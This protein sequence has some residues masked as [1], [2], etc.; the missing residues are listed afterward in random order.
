MEDVLSGTCSNHEDLMNGYIDD[1]EELGLRNRDVSIF[2]PRGD[3]FLQVFVG[4]TLYEPPFELVHGPTMY[5]NGS[6]GIAGPTDNTTGSLIDFRRGKI[7]DTDWISLD[8]V[9]KWYQMC[10]TVHGIECED[11][12]HRKKLVGRPSFLIDVFN[13]CI[14]SGKPE[15]LYIA[16]SYVWGKIFSC[17]LMKDNLETLQTAHALREVETAESI[18][19]TIRH[20]ID[21]TRQLGE[22]Y[23]WV[24]M[25][26]IVQDERDDLKAQELSKMGDIYQNACLTI[27]AADGGHADHG[28]RGIREISQPLKRSCTQHVFS[29]GKNAKAI[30]RMFRKQNEREEDDPYDPIT[31]YYRRAWTFQEY[32]FSRRRVIF[33]KGS[34]LW[35]CCCTTWFEDIDCS[36]G[37]KLGQSAILGRNI[38]LFQKGSPDLYNL[39][40]MVNS[41]NQRQ[42]TYEEDSLSAFSGLAS[43][44]SLSF[45]GGFLCGLPELFFDIALL[46]QPDGELRRRRNTSSEAAFSF[47]QSSTLPSWSWAGWAGWAGSTDVWSWQSGNDFVKRGSTGSE[48][49]RETLPITSW[50]SGEFPLPTDCREISGQWYT[51]KQHFQNLN[52]KPPKGWTRHESPGTPSGNTSWVYPDCPPPEGYGSYYFTHR[53]YPQLQFWYPIPLHEEGAG[54]TVRQPA[55]YLFASVDIATFYTRGIRLKFHTPSVTIEN[56]TGGWAGIL[57]P[58]RS[59]DISEDVR[60]KLQPLE[61]VAVSLG[62]ARNSEPEEPGLEE[63]HLDERPKKGRLYEFYNVL[64]TSKSGDISFR[65]GIGR[66]PR[67]IW[68]LRERRKVDLILG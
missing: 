31:V 22:R 62:T 59:G 68:E 5:E 21:L 7:I 19:I 67:A 1:W 23:L 66:V 64:W 39:M 32:L 55:R 40:K 25:L 3:S 61:L 11:Q 47:A 6:L 20:A 43:A 8:T 37:V 42:L 58:H 28:L 17:R 4:E 57:R 16:L 27:I 56:E 14:I 49:S 2:K 50:Y 48:T 24:D 15:C 34:V 9:G 12:P 36:D 41:F 26:C 13:Y 45:V 38:S 35:E 51:F 33:E 29:L 54:L 30:F 60:P 52:S 44:M 65:R 46:W 18:P 63:W 53:S 10:K